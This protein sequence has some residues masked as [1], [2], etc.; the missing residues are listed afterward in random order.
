[1]SRL[2][3]IL[4]IV[5]GLYLLLVLIDRFILVELLVR[6]IGVPVLLALFEAFAI[7]GVGFAVRGVLARGWNA[8]D[9]DL[10]RDFLLGY[11]LFG[12]LCF[13]VGTLNVSSWSMSIILMV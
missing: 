2:Q 12:A 11:P 5:V 8:E 3:R 4:A 1:M 6:R 13:L 10:P 7:I 9:A